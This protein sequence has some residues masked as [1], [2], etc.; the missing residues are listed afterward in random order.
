MSAATILVVEDESLIAADIELRLK[1]LG[2]NVCGIVDNAVDVLDFVSVIRPDLIL[3]DIHIKG[4]LSGI[5][6]SRR[7]RERYDIP[8]VFMTAHADTATLSDAAATEPYGY[9]VKPFDKR[10]LAAGVETALARRRAEASL[11]KME[12]WLATTLG[13]IGDAVLATDAEYRIAFINRVAEQLSGWSKEDALGR[14]LRSVAQ[15]VDESGE[16]LLRARIESVI[17]DGMSLNLEDAFLIRRDG[18][19]LPI[20][21]SV[22]PIRDDA[23]IV[24]GVVIAFRDNTERHRLEQQL[25]DLNSELER[26]VKVRTTELEAANQELEAFSHSI[27]HDLRAPLRA[28][29]AFSTRLAQDHSCQLDDEGRRLLGV[30]TSRTQQMSS[31]IDDY[32]RLSQVGRAPAQK[33]PLDMAALARNAWATVTAGEPTNAVLEMGRLPLAFGDPKLIEQV[34]ANLLSNSVKFSRHLAHPLIR[35]GGTED[36]RAVTFVVED[37]GIGLDPAHASK[38]FNMFERL[39]PTTELEGN[40]VGLAI[41]RRILN[42]H[43]G[44]VKIEGQPGKGVTV[45]FWL[46]KPTGAFAGLHAL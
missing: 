41:V 7:L 16:D 9:I 34:W 31:M 39:H 30:V 5:D 18:T 15:I 36:E 32:L 35:I 13:S 23:G 1:Q 3:M 17:V 8:I 2:Y 25:R 19:R 21:D 42:R 43:D 45:T 22:A 38:L 27:A 26:R 29:N 6:T 24:A 10:A 33:V 20:D 12:H 40:G 11:A 4:D 37:N 28:I 14:P 44:E 46:P